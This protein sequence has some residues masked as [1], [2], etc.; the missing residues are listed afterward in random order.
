MSERI[1]LWNVGASIWLCTLCMA[2][3]KKAKVLVFEPSSKSFLALMN[4]GK[5]NSFGD[6]V[7]PCF[8]ALNEKELLARAYIKSIEAGA[9]MH[10]FDSEVSADGRINV[11]FAQPTIGVSTYF[12]HSNFDLPPLEFVKIDKDGN[13]VRNSKGGR[14]ICMEHTRS[15][16]NLVQD[17][18]F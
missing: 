8:F 14:D 4:N 7:I 15:L 16:I 6:E 2:K 1:S 17:R 18:I 12:L 10:F 5:L 3:T 13:K 9:L 11:G